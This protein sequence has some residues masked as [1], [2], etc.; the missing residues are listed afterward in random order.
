MN[1]KRW[2]SIISAG[3]FLLACQSEEKIDLFKTIEMHILFEDS[4]FEIN[5]HWYGY[6]NPYNTCAPDFFLAYNWFEKRFELSFCKDLGRI[7]LN[8]IAV[9]NTPC[10]NAIIGIDVEENQ[11]IT[12]IFLLLSEEF[13][14]CFL[15]RDEIIGLSFEFE[16]LK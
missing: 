4:Q 3:I 7:E 5:G 9:N 12:N 10:V 1:V 16:Y 2:I 6:Q 11:D 13:N 15:D 14:Y 8:S